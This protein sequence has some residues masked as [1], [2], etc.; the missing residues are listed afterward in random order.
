MAS[1]RVIIEKRC[2]H[3]FSVVFYPILFILAVNDDMHESSKDFKIWPDPTTA[4]GVSSLERPLK[5]PH[6]LIMGKM[7]LPLF[8]SYY[9][10]NPFQT[11]R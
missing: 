3:F 1:D 4:C 7:V 2:C 10:S 11:C 8:L 5:N 9:K 6:R